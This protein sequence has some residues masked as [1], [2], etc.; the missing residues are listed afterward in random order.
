MRSVHLLLLT[1]CV[2]PAQNPEN[3]AADRALADFSKPGEG[4]RWRTV[5]DGVMGG[6]STGSFVVEDD[7]MVFTG[8]LN[9]N[10]GGF[11]SV[12]RRDDD[13]QLGQEG[14]QGIRVRLR[15]DGR[16]YTLRLRQ[17]VAGQRYA[18][19][20][21]TQFQT[22]G[23]DAWQDV[24]VPYRALQPT[25]RGRKLEL[26]AVDPSKV[27]ELG[28]SIDDKIDGP[29][30]VEIREVSTYA[31][32]DLSDLKNQRRPLI[33]FAE[34]QDTPALKQQ[35]EAA[36]ADASGFAERDIELIVVVDE[37]ASFAGSRPLAAADCAALRE[38]FR[39]NRS[40][41][42][43][44]FAAL[45]VGKDGSVKRT[46]LTPIP[47]ADLFAQIDSMPMRRRELRRQ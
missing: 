31:A 19:S 17:P 14:E 41:A 18:A 16:K 4:A 38:R 45:L 9:T 47:T 40:G 44:G 10:G 27:D 24:F 2:M 34:D 26:P 43:G 1:A 5:L 20:Y 29:F 37:G 3:P 39:R 33:V 7:A 13:L 30:R 21:R 15:G 35:L 28:F 8:V 46:S 22:K 42:A 6:R 25:W 32:F 23:G 11:S 12:R 36:R